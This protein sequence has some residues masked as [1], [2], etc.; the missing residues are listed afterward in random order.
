MSVVGDLA[1]QLLDSI[2]NDIAEAYGDEV[3]YV[4]FNDPELVQEDPGYY[5][6]NLVDIVED[7]DAGGGDQVELRFDIELTAV[8]PRPREKDEIPNV[9]LYKLVQMDR[10]SRL[11]MPGSRYSEVFYLPTIPSRRLQELDKAQDDRVEFAMTFRCR[12]TADHH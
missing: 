9:T 1:T 2:R 7:M 8:F 10:L 11:L 3:K 12:C 4:F 6:I 5:V